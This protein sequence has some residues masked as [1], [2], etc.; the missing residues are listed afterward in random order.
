MIVQVRPLFAEGLILRKEM[1]TA[2]SDQAFGLGDLLFCEHSDGILSGCRLSTTRDTI[3]MGPGTIFFGGTLYLL[4]MPLSVGYH[5]TDRLSLCKLRFSEECASGWGTYREVELVITEDSAQRTG[6]LEICRF[7]LQPDARLR[8]RYD[9]FEDRSTE[10]DT[11]NT[12]HAPYAA[13][14]GSTL[15]PAIMSAYAREL[16]AAFPSDNLD[17]MFCMNVLSASFPLP[18]DTIAAYIQL[19]TGGLPSP[20]SNETLYG[21]LLAILKSVQHGTDPKAKP[22][23]TAQWQLTI[24]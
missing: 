7:K 13:Q 6:E 21:G 3:E 17:Q 19:R 4:K 16:L 22:G 1:L 5:A 15:S 12:I 11:L 2:L 23:G 24:E 14:W 8:D 9:D 20:C 18:K 10:Y